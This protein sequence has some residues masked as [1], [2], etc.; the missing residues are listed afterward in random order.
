[1][2]SHEACP[3]LLTASWAFFEKQPSLVRKILNKL[4]SAGNGTK[5]YCIKLCRKHKRSNEATQLCELTQQD[6]DGL[7]CLCAQLG[8]L[9]PRPLVG[10]G[11]PALGTLLPAR[12]ITLSILRPSNEKIQNCRNIL[13]IFIYCEGSRTLGYYDL[14]YKD[15]KD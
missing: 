11:E 7:G 8:G 4:K 3:L 10:G 5:L 14:H 1:V 13:I 9:L 12:P 6:V 15:P 2:Y